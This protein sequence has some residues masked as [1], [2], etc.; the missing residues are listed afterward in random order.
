[1]AVV[2]ATK[3]RKIVFPGQ[4]MCGT[5]V[6]CSP[7]AFFLFLMVALLCLSLQHAPEGWGAPLGAP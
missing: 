7:M 4:G 5:V 3:K 2:T 6:L 1:M